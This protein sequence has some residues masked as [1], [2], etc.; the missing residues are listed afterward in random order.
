MDYIAFG[1]RHRIATQR[2]PLETGDRFRLLE[3]P[4]N[5]VATAR[6]PLNLV[7]SLSTEV[8]N[9]IRRPASFRRLE[10]LDACNASVVGPKTGADAGRAPEYSSLRQRAPGDLTT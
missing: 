8:P 7:A 9:E 10:P 4:P 1:P 6:A 5:L 2:S 3:G